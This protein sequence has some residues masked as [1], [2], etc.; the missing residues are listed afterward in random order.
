MLATLLLFFADDLSLALAEAALANSW[1]L[2]PCPAVGPTV[3]L[4]GVF[5]SALSCKL[6]S[7]ESLV[8]L[9][10]FFLKAMGGLGFG[11]GLSSLEIRR[12]F[13]RL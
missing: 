4:L 10:D 13:N 2:L 11:T 3:Y 8:E 6:V 1:A 9:P 12:N 7:D 5:S